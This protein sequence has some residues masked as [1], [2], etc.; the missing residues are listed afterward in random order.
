MK[1]F[2]TIG[3]ILS[4]SLF[5]CTSAPPTTR[6]FAKLHIYEKTI[7]LPPGGDALLGLLKEALYQEGWDIS[8]AIID[9]TITEKEENREVSY[10]KY[11]TEYILIPKYEYFSNWKSNDTIISFDFSLIETASGKEILTYSGEASMFDPYSFNE[12]VSGLIKALSIK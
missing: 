1:R 2:S 6:H 12:V 10:D 7:T 8:V 4:I 5:S 11:K 3:L 9:L